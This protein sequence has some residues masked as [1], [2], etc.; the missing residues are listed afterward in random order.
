MK[1]VAAPEPTRGA[2]RQSSG[3][4]RG[5]PAG[6]LAAPRRTWPIVAA[7]AAVLALQVALASASIQA[8]GA[9]R[10]YVGGESLY[11]KG[12]RSA[13]MALRD[14]LFSKEEADFERFSAAL[15]RPMGDGR[16]R[17][18]L[19]RSPPDL[20]AARQGFLAG[21]NDPQDVGSLIWLFRWFHNTRWFSPAVALW[22][23][24]DAGVQELAA[25]G[26]RAHD[27]IRAG[28]TEQAIAQ[29]HSSARTID[30][31]LTPLEA[32]FSFR[33]G[34]ASRQVG[35]VL[36][37]LNLGAAAVL[38]G[39]LIA[40]TRQRLRERA[41]AEREIARLLDTVGDAV[42]CV[43]TQRRIVLFNRAAEAIFRSPARERLGTEV[44]AL[45][46]AQEH[47]RLETLID[48]AA[49]ADSGE[50][51]V[52]RVHDLRAQ[53]ADG[54]SFP[55]EV[56]TSAVRTRIGPVTTIV[57][58]DVSDQERARAEREAR[59]ALEAA[60][61]AKSG[62]LS[63]MSH[64]LRTPL[65][66]V[67]GFARLMAMD[68][69][70]PLRE[71]DRRRIEHIEHAGS[72]LLALVND[73]LDLSRIEAGQMTVSLEPVD[74]AAVAER[75]LI[76]TA[77][78][79]MEARVRLSPL[80]TTD[81]PQNAAGNAVDRAPPR[82]V[83]ADRVRLQ[84]VLINLV[85]NAVKYTP[86]GGQ[87]DLTLRSREDCVDIIVSDTG[88]GMTPEQLAHLFEPFNRLGAERSKVEG[89]GIGL[90]LTRQFVALMNGRLGVDSA[91]GLGTRVTVSLCAAAAP[92]VAS[93]PESFEEVSISRHFKPLEVI[94]VEDNE[95]N[96]EL[97]RQILAL[98]C[99]VTLRVA[100]TGAE[101]LALAG[102]QPPGL[103]L[104]DMHLGDMT[105]MEL[106]ARLRASDAT[107]S[108][109]LVAVSADA[110]PDQIEH[111]LGEGFDDYITKPVAPAQLVQVISKHQAR[112]HF[113]P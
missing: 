97:M 41:A 49:P 11:S 72:H 57:L 25:L 3:A 104:V 62:F 39:I 40:F 54:T 44:A 75:V 68:E 70:S 108:I 16:A 58:R 43:D 112:S 27:A 81:D 12:R 42:I 88:K 15:S 107:A 79:A 102:A 113:A 47:S 63:S 23:E 61:Q 30:T 85:S 51:L 106:A 82:F 74:A 8:L 20:R 65:N 101:A 2:A 95:V 60:N 48:E 37:A 109:P 14:Y 66:A 99:R 46:A 31:R 105:G 29:L 24:G 89:T 7:A 71:E 86:A 87:V 55:A 73:V 26:E 80:A 45:A 10:A 21:G 100:T 83:L 78:A 34:E 19:E 53:R 50:D 94:Y 91:P 17:E 52:L 33:L 67:I 77:Q 84:Q 1:A 64:E 96:V 93:P 38:G 35:F 5:L 6:L 9:V 92:V 69:T 36:L 28:A 59:L 103:M 4:R 76:M 110:L 111:A 32:E 22:R 98:R 56:S 90:V 13:Q 18:A